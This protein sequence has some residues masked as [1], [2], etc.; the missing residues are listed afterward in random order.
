MFRETIQY[1]VNYAVARDGDD[2]IVFQWELLYYFVRMSGMCG[3]YEERKYKM[4]GHSV[5]MWG[6]GGLQVMSSTH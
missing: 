1:F 3:I 5:D 2:C 6:G 4:Q